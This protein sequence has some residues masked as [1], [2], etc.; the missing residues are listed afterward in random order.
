MYFGIDIKL[1][2]TK[3]SQ[4]KLNKMTNLLEM[5]HAELMIASNEVRNAYIKADIENK[6]KMAINLIAQGYKHIQFQYGCIKRIK[7]ND[8]YVYVIKSGSGN[9]K[10]KTIYTTLLDAVTEV[11]NFGWGNIVSYK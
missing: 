5:T 3:Q 1:I 7:K 9:G 8:S 2:F 10:H 6:H 11:K 4:Q